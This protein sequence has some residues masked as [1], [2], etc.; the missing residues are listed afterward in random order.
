M[1]AVPLRDLGTIHTSGLVAMVDDRRNSDQAR[2]EK[3]SDREEK[4]RRDRKQYDQVAET[5][6]SAENWRCRCTAS[7]L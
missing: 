1:G 7:S 5:E 2:Y 3:A 4:A 6:F